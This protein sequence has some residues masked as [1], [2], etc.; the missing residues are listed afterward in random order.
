MSGLARTTIAIMCDKV[1]T[2]WLCRR[3]GLLAVCSLGRSQDVVVPL[4]LQISLKV[5]YIMM[6]CVWMEEQIN[7]QIIQRLLTLQKSYFH[8]QFNSVRSCFSA[9]GAHLRK[10]YVRPSCTRVGVAHWRKP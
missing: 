3:G 5:V 10:L 2:A 8:G 9:S 6:E 7:R 4:L 1:D